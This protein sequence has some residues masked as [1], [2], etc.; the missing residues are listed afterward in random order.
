MRV[1]VI[2]TATRR[3]SIAAFGGSA[4]RALVTNDQPMTQAERIMGGVDDVLA[5]SGWQPHDAELL[6]T[7][8]GP[9]SFTGVRV[10]MATAKGLAFAL[11][12]PLVGVVSLEAMA[13]AARA[14][15]GPETVIALLDAKKGEV[16]AAAYGPDGSTVHDPVHLAR[17]GVGEWIGRIDPGRG[18]VAIGEVLADLELSGVRTMRHPDCDLPAPAAMAR[19]GA[20]RWAALPGGELD[21]LQPLYVRPPDI[22]VPRG[23]Q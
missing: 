21:P 8:R 12:R 20:I 9:G 4:L 11:D 2:D 6:V 18:A 10:G 15:A 5:A 7:G 22:H 3:S 1:L 16:Y 23:R 13:W 19:L 14:L 17:Q